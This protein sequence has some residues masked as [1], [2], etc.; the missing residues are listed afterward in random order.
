MHLLVSERIKATG[1]ERTREELDAMKTANEE[2]QR[3]KL[4]VEEQ[5]GHKKARV[6][7]LKKELNALM[8]LGDLE[9]KIKDAAARLLWFEVNS[10]Q[11]DVQK[12][13]GEMQQ[14]EEKLTEQVTV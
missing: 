8:L 14:S 10:K 13:I 4:L 1:L 5:A 7:A 9:D 2:T 6:D 12:A 3:S 11:K